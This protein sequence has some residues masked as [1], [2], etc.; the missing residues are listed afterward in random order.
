MKQIWNILLLAVVLLCSCGGK[1]TAPQEQGDTISLQYAR[2]LTLVKYDGYTLAN[3]TD[4]W[5]QGKLLHQYALVPQGKKGDALVSTLEAKKYTVVRT[6]VKRSIVFTTTHCSLLTDLGAQ[7][8]ITGVCDFKYIN[9]PWIQK[10]VKARRLADCGDGMNADVEKIID[11]KPQVLLL[12]PFEN[13]GGYGKLEEIH[14]PLIECAEYMETSS[15]GRA[16]W[17]KFYG[18]LYGKEKEANALFTAIVHE[19]QRLKALAMSTKKRPVVI[20]ERKTGSVWYVPGGGSTTAATIKDA[21]GQYAFADNKSQGSLSLS[22][23]KVLDKA[24]QADIWFFKYNDHPANMQ[25]LLAEYHGYSQ[26]K[27]FQNRQVFGANCT[28][29]PFFEESGF[30]PEYVLRDMIIILHPELKIGT[31]KYYHRLK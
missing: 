28:V 24:G 17:M 19:Y 5:R 30:H 18:L 13:S 26:L 11:A 20:T 3:L 12:S 23:E 7:Q 15:L 6:P 4:P 1:N 21:G 27:A 8:A 22:F 16:E 2:H 29:V 31:L 25:E 9:I 10:A 14:I